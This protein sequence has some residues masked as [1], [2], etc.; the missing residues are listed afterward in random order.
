MTPDAV[1]LTFPWHRL[2]NTE[3]RTFSFL[4]LCLATVSQLHIFF[5]F[6]LENKIT[7]RNVQNR[8]F[9]HCGNTELSSA[10]AWCFREVRDVVVRIVDGRGVTVHRSSLVELLW[11]HN[12]CGGRT[13]P[14]SQVAKL[15]VARAEVRLT[16]ALGSG[17]FGKTVRTGASVRLVSKRPC[18]N[19]RRRRVKYENGEG[20]MKRDDMRQTPFF[21][22]LEPCVCVTRMKMCE[23]SADN[24]SKDLFS[25]FEICKN[26]GYRLSGRS[27]RQ[28]HHWRHEAQDQHEAQ[29]ETQQC[30]QRLKTLGEHVSVCVVVAVFVVSLCF[31]CRH[32]HPLHIAHWLKMFAFASHSIPWSSLCRMH[33]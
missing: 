16:R 13:W 11:A 26:L 29:H 25:R 12:L 27:Q 20:E 8:G 19:S 14:G 6:S 30:V 22:D 7:M 10:P 24:T 2:S 17:K 5:A 23:V 28:E 31:C 1:P 3:H 18:R 33:E 9:K 4:S 32:T 15:L 21:H